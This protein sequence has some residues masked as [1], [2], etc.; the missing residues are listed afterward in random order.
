MKK[1]TLQK[2]MGRLV[3]FSWFLPLLT[4]TLTMLFVTNRYIRTKTERTIR[5]TM[6]KAVEICNMNLNNC[7]SESK[8]I[9]YDSNIEQVY[10]SYQESHDSYAF[11]MNVKRI[12]TKKYKFNQEF[13]M[14]GIYFTEVPNMFYATGLDQLGES[15]AYFEEESKEDILKLAKTIDTKTVFYKHNDHVYMVRN[16]M[17][18]KFEPYAVL[19]MELNWKSIFEPLN[20]VWQ[21]DQWYVNC[22]NQPLATNTTF[23]TLPKL[24]YSNDRKI[25]FTDD[26]YVYTTTTLGRNKFHYSGHLDHAL[27]RKELTYIRLLFV[28]MCALV[29]PLIYGVFK[30]LK[31]RIIHPIHTLQSASGE[32]ASGN[33][34]VRV[35]VKAQ[36]DEIAE[37]QENFNSMG[38]KLQYQFE[39]L[40]GE[41]LALKD[42]KLHAL[43]L[44]INPHFLNN[45]L[46]I[47]NWEARLAGNEKLADMI[48][49]LCVMM[50][51]TMNR[52]KEPLIPL[53][54]ELSYVEAYIYIIECRFKDRFTFH[55]E[56]SASDEY[57]VPRLIIQPIIENAVDFAGDENGYS[58]VGLYITGGKDESDD[59]KIEVINNGEL[60][61]E[62]EERISMLLSSKQVN[63]KKSTHIGIS[64]VNRRLKMIY[65][66]ESCLTITKDG[67]GNTVTTII[68]K[69]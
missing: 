15:Q 58:E 48:E 43:E 45:T 38:E 62:D 17:N 51:A 11:Y 21:C 30:F 18:H 63:D 36:M 13:V 53:Y 14:S 20:A 65:N 29:F 64:N 50:D 12:M 44:Q 22:N 41:E 26:N 28:V 10:S 37:L 23:E 4:L 57:M 5:V 9:N 49:A 32:I 66:K 31:K 34:S 55:Q 59:L 8:D 39:K 54:E 61:K 1:N 69:K 35:P 7:V 60:S 46:E 47:I 42:A 52:K 2:S 24:S 40:Y 56:I 3:M 19:L 16:I 68:I 67:K 27:L 25:H 33:Y 6:E